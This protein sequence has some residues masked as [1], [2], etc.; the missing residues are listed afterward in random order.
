MLQAHYDTVVPRQ[1]RTAG[2]RRSL[3][4]V[5][6][7]ARRIRRSVEGTHAKSSKHEGSS[8]SIYEVTTST[9]YRG[10]YGDLVQFRC[11]Q[12]AQAFST[13]PK[14]HSTFPGLPQAATLQSHNPAGGIDA[15]P[16]TGRLIL[17]K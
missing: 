8:S 12:H 2:K 6:R 1:Q 7:Q 3:N 13:A 15:A 17:H 16:S 4:A 11:S 5:E 9:P 14:W 10:E